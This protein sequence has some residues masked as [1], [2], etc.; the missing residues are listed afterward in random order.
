MKIR[1]GCEDEG[2]DV[3]IK[4]GREDEVKIKGCEDKGRV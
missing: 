4:E 2:R 3:N 1:K